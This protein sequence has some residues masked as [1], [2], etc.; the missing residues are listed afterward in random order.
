MS[1]HTH[2]YGCRSKG[3]KVEFTLRVEVALGILHDPSRAKNKVMGHNE[4]VTRVGLP[5][6]E[7]INILAYLTASKFIG[8]FSRIAE[9]L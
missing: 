1:C 7:L 5:E 9:S 2:R 3:L 4:I 6:P 8:V